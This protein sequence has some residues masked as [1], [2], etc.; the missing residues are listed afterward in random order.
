M[1][2]P[3]ACA[4]PQAA[5]ASKAAAKHVQADV[6]MARLLASLVPYIPPARR[7]NGQSN[8]VARGGARP[9]RL[10]ACLPRTARG[11]NHRQFSC[12]AGRL[13]RIRLRLSRR[14]QLSPLGHS[15]ELAPE[16]LPYVTGGVGGARGV[17]RVRWGYLPR[18]WRSCLRFG[19]TFARANVS[20][21]WRQRRFS[22]DFLSLP[23]GASCAIYALV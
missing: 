14:R 9:Q 16:H 10:F 3:S 11:V 21:V 19:D 8:T 5:I 4:Q 17:W 22:E 7:H 1:N 6:Q 20:R 12:P 2:S 23:A 18:S 15:P 13:R